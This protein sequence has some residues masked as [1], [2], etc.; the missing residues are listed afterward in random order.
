MTLG[1][2]LETHPLLKMLNLGAQLVVRPAHEIDVGSGRLAH[3]RR[4]GTGRRQ[5][6]QVEEG[7][8]EAIQILYTPGHISVR[9]ECAQEAALCPVTVGAAAKIPKERPTHDCHPQASCQHLQVG[10]H[11][12]QTCIALLTCARAENATLMS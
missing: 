10:S 6:Q 5:G 3:G 4:R 11:E 9:R 2:A 8:A 1:H 12:R 7:Q